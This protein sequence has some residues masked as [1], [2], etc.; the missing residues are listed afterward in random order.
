MVSPSISMTS[1]RES[2]HFELLCASLVPI[3]NW[4]AAFAAYNKPSMNVTGN[5]G[6]AQARIRIATNP[7]RSGVQYN[8]SLIGVPSNW[9][10]EFPLQAR[11][12]AYADDKAAWAAIQTDPGLAIIDGTVVPNNF[13]PNFGSFTAVLNDAF[14]FRNMTGATRTVR[15]IGILHEQ[16]AQGLSVSSSTVKRH[17]GLAAATLLYFHIRAGIAVTPAALD[18]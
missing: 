16:F 10:P 17:F 9:T 1:Y 7:N 3:P 13:G 4:E 12:P 8:S 15:V 5:H 14:H 6:I 11:D 2:G 18:R